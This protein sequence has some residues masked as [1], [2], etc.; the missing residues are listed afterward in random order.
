MLKEFAKYLVSLGETKSFEINGDTY[1][2]GQVYYVEPHVD[3]PERIIVSGLDSIV[4]LIR[5]ENDVITALPI[6]IRVADERTVSVFTSFDEY[7]KR[8]SL[9]EA[10]CD[11]P[12]FSEGFRGYERAIIELR[13]RFIP[14]DGT[15]YLLDL[16][17]RVNVE[18]G[19][20]T[21]DNGV[22][23]TVEARSGVSLKQMV[24]IRPR[25]SLAP[26]RTFLEVDQPASEFLLRLNDDGDV[27]LFEADGGMWKLEAKAYIMDYFTRELSDEIAAGR[28][29]V[30]M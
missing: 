18:N 27:G 30:M 20:S 23:Q 3:R 8:D 5:N 10:R 19:V 29:A 16:L 25:I 17:S 12:G 22:S 1:V 7:M 28:V 9:Y 26:Y 2:D 6:F 14:G 13:S 15:E 4:K 24:A 11:V 21:A